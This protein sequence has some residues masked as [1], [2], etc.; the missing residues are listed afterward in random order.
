[1]AR[2]VYI[3]D[4]HYGANPVIYQQQQAYPEMLEELIALLDSWIVRDGE[5]DFVLHGGDLVDS[6]SRDNVRA[7]RK[8]LQLSVPVY[9]CLGNHDLTDPDALAIWLAEA[10]ELF[11]NRNPNYSLETED[12]LVHVVPNQWCETPYYWQLEQKPHFTPDQVDAL[13][14][15]LTI[16]PNAVHVLCTHSPVLGVPGE[17]TGFDGTYHDPDE[18]FTRRVSEIVSQHQHVR[19]VLG[20]HSHINTCVE[21]GS[22]H[23][24]TGSAFVETPFEFKLFEIGPGSVRM[25][26][27]SLALQVSFKAEYN[28]DKTY[29]QGRSRDR[30]FETLPL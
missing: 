23:F 30:K 29:V 16:S 9:L 21:R 19:C 24:V 26:T 10:P 25:C 2:F 17:Q 13:R 1:M 12:C 8:L 20:G 15:K 7:A 22:T 5:I 3:T 4:T 27:L 28:Y 6:A 11:P 18:A 14:E